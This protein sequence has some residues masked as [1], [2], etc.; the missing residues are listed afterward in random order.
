MHRLRFTSRWAAAL[1]LA[2][3]I[4]LVA[5]CATI[6]QGSTQQVSMSSSPTGAEITVNG[7]NLGVT[8]AA[9]ELKRKDNHVIRVQMD[10]YQPYEVAL[11]RSVSGWVWGNIVF[12]GIP[13]LA[14]D[15]ITGALYKLSPEQIMANLAQ[16]EGAEASLEE[17]RLYVF[18]TLAA[19]PSW[20]PI[21]RLEEE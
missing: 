9:I 8:P 18:V 5:G 14:V 3:L 21:G 6:M 12:G 10:G 17:D 7:R 11:A 1:A 2:V 16:G 13:G 15:A 4:P 19:D 20:T